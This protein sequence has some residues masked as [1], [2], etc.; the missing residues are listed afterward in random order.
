VLAREP[1]AITMGEGVRHFDGLLAPIACV[2]TSGYRWCSQESVCRFRRVLLEIRNLTT[3][4]M[5]GA[6]LAAV[7]EGKPVTR[8]EV[9]E[10]ELTGGGGI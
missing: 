7:H 1:G 6:T 2:S 10:P 3:R 8:E 9:F 4:L 5:D